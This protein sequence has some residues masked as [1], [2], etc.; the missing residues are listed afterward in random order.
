MYTL[1]S[2][3]GEVL[4]GEGAVVWGRGE[5]HLSPC[6]AERQPC[7]PS[8]CLHGAECTEVETVGGGVPY[9]HCSGTGYRGDLCEVGVVSIPSLPLLTVGETHTFVVSAKPDSNLTVEFESKLHLMPS[10]LTF[11]PSVTEVMVNITPS[12]VG[13]YT[14]NAKLSGTNAYSYDTPSDMTVVVR[15]RVP[16]DNVDEI[17]SPG[18]CSNES[19][20]VHSCLGTSSTITFYSTCRH[21]T[22]K[23]EDKAR[24]LEGMSFTTAGGLS[25]PLSLHSVRLQSSGARGISFQMSPYE[26]EDGTSQCTSCGHQEECSGEWDCSCYDPAPSMAYYLQRESLAKT[27][28]QNIAPLLPSW[29]ELEA[30]ESDRL[31]DDHSY[32]VELVDSVDLLR[33]PQCRGFFSTKNIDF[34]TYSVLVYSGTFRVTVGGDTVTYTPSGKDALCVAVNLCEGSASPV[35]ISLPTAFRF[36]QFSALDALSMAGWKLEEVTGLVVMATSQLEYYVEKADLIMTAKVSFAGTQGGTRL[37]LSF[38]GVVRLNSTTPLSQ[39][40]CW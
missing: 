17:L 7:L 23:W 11:S 19:E 15:S 30:V 25:L 3:R 40:S 21:E 33:I 35:Y 37:G 22:H 12:G 32:R 4:S 13:V 14:V 8:P 20:S 29:M 6:P 38:D 31:Y 1:D 9:C 24:I 5:G 16:I 27:Y 18:C 39:V 28:L 26:S 10:V 36:E 2:V 34:G